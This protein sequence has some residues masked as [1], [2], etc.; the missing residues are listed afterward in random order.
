[1][2]RQLVRAVLK[3]LPVEEA[4]LLFSPPASEL[5]AS[6]QGTCKGTKLWIRQERNGCKK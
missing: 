4:A 6:Q 3:L 1:M 2:L 5:R